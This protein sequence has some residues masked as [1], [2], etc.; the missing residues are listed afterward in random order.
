VNRLMCL[1]FS[2]F[3]ASSFASN[4]QQAPADISQKF[5]TIFTQID[6][7]NAFV[8]QVKTLVS[9]EPE[10]NIVQQF[11]VTTTIVLQNTMSKST[12]S[13]NQNGFNQ[14]L[15]LNGDSAEAYFRALP[16][17]QLFPLDAQK[18]D[19]ASNFTY[20]PVS[21]VNQL[22]WQKPLATSAQTDN[23]NNLLLA[24]SSFLKKPVQVMF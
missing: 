3:V 5:L 11:S 8:T 16:R 2:I 13:V 18:T 10:S 23:R 6:Q 14:P 7:T 24:P 21:A 1:F 15:D 9:Y 4:Y 12:G 20:S 22:S 19:D 17:D